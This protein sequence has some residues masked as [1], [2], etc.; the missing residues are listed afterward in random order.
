MMLC[1]YILGNLQTLW[2]KMSSFDCIR[3]SDLKQHL[4]SLTDEDLYQIIELNSEW[5]IYIAPSRQT[6]KLC[7]LAIKKKPNNMTYVVNQDEELCIEAVSENSY[8]L[9][10]ITNQTPRII[11]AA[12]KRDKYATAYIKPKCDTRCL[13]RSSIILNDNKF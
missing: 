2:F 10:L 9:S 3:K 6:K 5:F 7:L 11:Q 1:Y 12:L 13:R 8:V 4:N